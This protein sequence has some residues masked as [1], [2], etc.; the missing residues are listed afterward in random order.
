M[1]MNKVDDVIRFMSVNEK[2]KWKKKF[3][4]KWETKFI[5]K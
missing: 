3:F 2:D 1:S 5:K 4:K